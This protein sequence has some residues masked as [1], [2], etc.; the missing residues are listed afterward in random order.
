MI[1]FISLFML[2]NLV[3][4][5]LVMRNYFFGLQKP[6]V[7]LNNDIDIKICRVK[8]EIEDRKL[9]LLSFLPFYG[10]A[11]MSGIMLSK[12]LNVIVKR[13]IIIVEYKFKGHFVTQFVLI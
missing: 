10:Q 11:T 6:T 1:S 4:F 2:L 9:L 7:V 8:R 5:M 3:I 12:L 13:K